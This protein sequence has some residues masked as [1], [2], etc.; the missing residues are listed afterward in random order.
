[1][2]IKVA[3][4]TLAQ[5]D[6][7]VAK[8]EG[9]P[10]WI[11]TGN[12]YPHLVRRALY[13]AD[14]NYAPCIDPA[15]AWPI[16]ERERPWVRGSADASPAIADLVTPDRKWFAYASLR[17]EGGDFHCYYGETFLIA[18]MRCYVA[19]V[20]GKEVEVPEELA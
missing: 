17:H 8:C 13:S 1:M 3:D 4:A 18:A 12:E 5:I 11:A 2:K 10:V 20:L 15:I 7:L 14:P 6:W 9:T 19:S 16:I